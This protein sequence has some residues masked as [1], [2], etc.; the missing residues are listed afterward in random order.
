[1]LLDLQLPDS[2]GLDTVVQFRTAVP[3][4][5]IIVLTASEEDGMGQQ[6]LSQG[7]QDYLTKD[8]VTIHNLMRT[9]RYAMKRSQILQQLQNAL[10]QRE[11][12]LQEV[13]H[14]VKNNMQTVAS[15]L[16]LQA[17]AVTDEQ[18]L[19]LFKE[20]QERIEAMALIHE[21][22]Y[23]SPN[24]HEIAAIG[25]FHRLTE[26]LL[27]SHRTTADSVNLKLDIANVLL[28]LNA[29]IPCGLIVNELVTNSLQHAFPDQGV[30]EIFI[31]L[32]KNTEITSSDAA[33]DSLTLI[34][35]D[36]GIGLPPG[37]DIRQVQSSLGLQLVRSLT[38]QLN[39]TLDINTNNGTMFRITFTPK[40]ESN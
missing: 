10:R 24:M 21:M 29:A 19:K 13:H 4:I 5:P 12:L 36:N 14:R 37:V 9:I 27:R 38:R 30:G 39:S 31:Q 34:V 23:Q 6:A 8:Q 28:D 33:A 32:M 25:Y 11:V 16:R 26:N 3:D 15:L 18:T 1:V 22:L 20:C 17:R 35:S 2:E 7:A 40:R